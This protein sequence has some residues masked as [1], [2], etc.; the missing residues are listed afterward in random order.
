M[1][2]ATIVSG[3]ELNLSDEYTHLYADDLAELPCLL[4]NRASGRSKYQYF[5]LIP[6]LR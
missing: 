1:S 3:W 2:D 4:I 6:K 5:T